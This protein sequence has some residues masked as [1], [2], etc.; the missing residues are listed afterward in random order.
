[1][2]TENSNCNSNGQLRKG[3]TFY[4]YPAAKQWKNI[5]GGGKLEVQKRRQKKMG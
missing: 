2:W 4:I 1:M 5:I 3:A